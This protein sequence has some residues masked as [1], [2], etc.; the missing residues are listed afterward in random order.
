MAI[1]IHTSCEKKQSPSVLPKSYKLLLSQYGG[2]S[3][4][5]LCMNVVTGSGYVKGQC[6]VDE[7]M[8]PPNCTRKRLVPHCL[9]RESV[10]MYGLGESV[11][12]NSPTTVSPLNGVLEA[13]RRK[14]SA[15]TA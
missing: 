12:F 4:H 13:Q 15:W 6:D 7:L 8:I 1:L 5:N 11:T 14:L 3:G 2:I 9:S 10:L